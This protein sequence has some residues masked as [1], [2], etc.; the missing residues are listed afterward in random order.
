[1]DVQQLAMFAAVARHRNLTK[2]SVEL[3][4]SQP[5]LSRDL[6]ELQERC[7]ARLLRRV[8]K[9][10]RLTPEGE[11]FLRRARPI[12]DQMTALESSFATQVAKETPKVLRVGGTFSASS[13]LLPRLLV[14]VRRRYPDAEMV[15]RTR[16]SDQLERLVLTGA[17]DLAVTARLA[18]SAEFV[19]EPLLRE[20]IALFVRADHRLAKKA[21]LTLADVAKEPIVL[22]GGQG[23][24]GMT[25]QAL[26][27]LRNGG[28]VLKI[29]MHCDGPTSIKAA[30]R[31]RMGVGVIL[32]NSIRP[33]VASGEFKILKIPGLDLAGQSYIVYSK[34]RPLSP[35]AQEFLEMLRGEGERRRALKSS[36]RSNRSS[37][38][39]RSNR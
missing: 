9:G 39:L 27:A 38:S 19:C 13:E 34:K 4:R 31:Q 5:A 23:G 29:A 36:K 14:G 28:S 7:G 22:R 10:V 12:L 11:A 25:D 32:V 1:M 18:P 2:A 24:S 15:I 17:M 6:K 33:E 8:W 16:T 20:E 21:N 3:G 26:M 35:I 30:V 37:A